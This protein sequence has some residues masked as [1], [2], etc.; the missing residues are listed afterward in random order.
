MMF[1]KKLRRYLHLKKNSSKSPGIRRSSSPTL[2][3][4][5]IYVSAVFIILFYPNVFQKTPIAARKYPA[6][7]QQSSSNGDNNGDIFAPKFDVSRYPN[8][9]KQSTALKSSRSYAQCALHFRFRFSK[10]A[11]ANPKK[12]K[13]T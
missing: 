9:R 7:S 3:P 12:T 8:L 11:H 6:A 2:K 1:L 10:S 5:E 4:S 13:H